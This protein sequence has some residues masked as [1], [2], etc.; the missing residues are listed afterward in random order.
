M[1]IGSLNTLNNT[2][3]NIIN[4]KK[5]KLSNPLIH[6]D[7]S[8][9]PAQSRTSFTPSSSSKPATTT[10]ARNDRRT[11]ARKSFE[12][13]FDE[14][15]QEGDEE[16]CLDAENDSDTGSVTLADLPEK[17]Q[18]DVTKNLISSLQSPSS[19]RFEGYNYSN[20]TLPTP[21][22][23]YSSKLNITSRSQ[24]NSI[25]ARLIFVLPLATK[26]VK[27]TLDDNTMSSTVLF[28]II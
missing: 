16:T 15:D 11:T 12:E 21:S 28:F 13:L 6:G 9:Q 5:R 26:D 1:N 18:L 3:T 22:N 7:T 19:Y 8:A 27:D 17:L 20:N 25:T 2:N 23:I 4:K 10:H 14:S 24:D